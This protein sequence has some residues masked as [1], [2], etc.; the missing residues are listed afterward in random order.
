MEE[1]LIA[2]LYFLGKINGKWDGIH[3]YPHQ[4]HLPCRLDLFPDGCSKQQFLGKWW[5][6]SP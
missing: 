6:I 4:L 2:D 3:G 5:S 1:A